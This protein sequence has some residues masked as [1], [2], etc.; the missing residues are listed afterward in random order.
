MTRKLRTSLTRLNEI[1]IVQLGTVRRTEHPVASFSYIVRLRP[2]VCGTVYLMV[3][4]IVYHIS[5][6]LRC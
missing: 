6:T 4:V 1:K 3:Y 2:F 5:L